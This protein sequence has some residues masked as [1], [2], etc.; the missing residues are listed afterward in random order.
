MVNIL[1]VTHEEK[2]KDFLGNILGPDYFIVTCDGEQKIEGLLPLVDLVIVDFS[3]LGWESLKVISLA[4]KSSHLIDVF[5]IGKEVNKEII[6]AAQGRGLSEYIDVDKDISFLPKLVKDKV[7][8]QILISKIEEKKISENLSLSP[9]EEEKNSSLE[10]WKFL[11]DMSRFLAYGY[12]LNELL[13]FFLN[14]LSRIFGVTKLCILLGDRVKNTY[15]VKACLGLSEETKKY[16]RLHSERGLAKF[17]A[18]E[19]TVVTRENFPHTDLKTTY[20]IRQDMKLI[21]C[22]TAIPLS[23]Q[24]R[25]IGILGI[26]PKIT[27]ENISL[28]EIKQ[29]FL[30][31]NQVGLAI[32][33]LLFYEEMSWHKRYIE[34]VLENASS[35][36]ISI[37]TEPRI[38]TC[39]P[40]A[41]KILK[42]SESSNLIGKDIRS[43]PSPLA[44]LL[45]ETLNKGISHERKEV[46]VPAIRSWL[47]INTSQTRDAEGKV[48]GSMMIFTDLTPVKELEEEKKKA[49]K[50]DFLAQ[51]ATRLS[52]E[53]R[54]SFVPI[55]SLAELLPSKY[56]DEEFQKTLFSVVT[57]EIE[58]INDLIERLVFF[59]QPLKLEKTAESLPDLINETLEKAKKRVPPDKDVQ[60][61]ITCKEET[62][63][64]YV[65]KKAII[66]AFENI[67]ANSIEAVEEK[68]AKI[69]INCEVISEL[70]DKTSIKVEKKIKSQ[71]PGQYIKIE[72]KDNGPGLPEERNSNSIFDPFF[73]TKNRGIGLGLTISQSIIEEHGGSIVPLSK[74]GEG[75]T[76]MVYLPRYQP[77]T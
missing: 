11:E 36:V 58:R 22:N 54:N 4:R 60:M 15:T 24:G 18:R 66:E 20:E 43:L 73:T 74:K 5:G 34:K 61:N 55:K 38:V 57:Q 9:I 75:T 7:E 67:V 2:R 10:E 41:Q 45:F 76:M 27:G 30:F 68:I 64:I 70:P 19:G 26:G 25:L 62:L 52:H 46:Y 28:K 31:S 40:R 23:P 14:F 53:L 72:F 69:D 12:N 17:L 44:D 59:S 35:G 16:A 1:F 13:Q 71:Q 49:Q 32:Q 39:N 48:I 63:Q 47:G 50:R 3:S 6:K 21:Q 77:P 42:L 51:V 8:K 37:D 65:D 56:L 33:N 29:I